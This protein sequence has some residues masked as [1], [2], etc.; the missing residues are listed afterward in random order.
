MQVIKS[1][2]VDGLSKT[3]KLKLD[4]IERHTKPVGPK[5]KRQRPV[6]TE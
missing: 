1:K 2:V 6:E 5:P 3:T 4:K